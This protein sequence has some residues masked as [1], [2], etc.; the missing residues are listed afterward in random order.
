LKR[1]KFVSW[2]HKLL[3]GIEF[4]MQFTGFE[5]AWQDIAEQNAAPDRCK[6]RRC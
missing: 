4:L 5:L 6:A 2:M 3:T 1:S